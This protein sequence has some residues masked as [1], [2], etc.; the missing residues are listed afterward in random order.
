LKDKLDEAH[1]YDLAVIVDIYIPTYSTSHNLYEDEDDNM[2][3]KQKVR[4]LVYQHKDHPALLIWNLGNEVNYPLV[5]RQE[6]FY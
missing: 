3:L 4:D 1:R 5:F 6:R 2:L